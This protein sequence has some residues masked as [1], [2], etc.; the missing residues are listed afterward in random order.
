[1]CSSRTE[2]EYLFSV[3]CLHSIV[4]AW[5]RDFRTIFYFIST[6][7]AEWV[8]AVYQVSF[9]VYKKS[10]TNDA[11]KN[12]WVEPDEAYSADSTNDKQS[13]SYIPQTFI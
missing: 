10:Y 2:S 9:V 1:M 7:N 12:K 5:N 6:F 4:K 8:F 11:E 13:A 3:Q